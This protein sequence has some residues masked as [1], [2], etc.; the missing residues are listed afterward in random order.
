M[1]GFDVS[2]LGPAG[3]RRHFVRKAGMP[4]PL[5][6]DKAQRRGFGAICARAAQLRAAVAF[7][8]ARKGRR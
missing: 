2:S 4:R 5:G 8:A 1:V 3:H 6:S 7:Q